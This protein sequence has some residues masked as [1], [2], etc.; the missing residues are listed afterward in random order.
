MTK[1]SAAYKIVVMADG[2][3]P[4][5]DGE[6]DS[7]EAARE[8]LSNYTEQM[9]PDPVVGGG[10]PV[11]RD[12]DDLIILGPD[13]KP[14]EIWNRDEE[15]TADHYDGKFDFADWLSSASKSQIGWQIVNAEGY[16]IHGEEDDPFGMNS[17]DVLVGDAVDTAR[18]WAA[19][20]PGYEVVPI[21]AADIDGPSFVERI[22]RADRTSVPAM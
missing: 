21:S 20:N 16:N 11:F 12:D 4:Y 10:V 2:N 19:E 7:E 8:A 22:V 1:D 6:F 13:N 14:V 9:M 3:T 5:I 18:Q 17:F 15:R